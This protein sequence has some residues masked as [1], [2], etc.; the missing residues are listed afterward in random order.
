MTARNDDAGGSRRS[1]DGQT[2]L[3]WLAE[4][5]DTAHDL[6]FPVGAVGFGRT[7]LACKA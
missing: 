6:E 2:I 1:N 3:N 4:T 7:A 5:P